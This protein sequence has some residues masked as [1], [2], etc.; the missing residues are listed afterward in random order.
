MI[1]VEVT[2]WELRENFDLATRGSI[3]DLAGGSGAKTL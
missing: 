2:V 3:N 1:L